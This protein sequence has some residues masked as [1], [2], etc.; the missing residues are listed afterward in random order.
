MR[1]VVVGDYLAGDAPALV[2]TG[3]ADA[4]AAGK[5][6]ILSSALYRLVE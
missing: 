5:A 2:G 6:H 1:V 4:D 3:E